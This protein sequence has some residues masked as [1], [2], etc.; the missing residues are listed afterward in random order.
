MG[1]HRPHHQP[2]APLL[3]P[4]NQD[5]FQVPNGVEAAL[6]AIT[7]STLQGPELF[8]VPIQTLGLLKYTHVAWH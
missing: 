2:L 1:V 3:L 5:S 7:S 4:P 6:V 8:W